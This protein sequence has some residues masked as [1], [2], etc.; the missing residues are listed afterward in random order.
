[1]NILHLDSSILGTGSVTRSLGQRLAQRLADE[2]PHAR[3]SYRDLAADPIPH[4]TGESLAAQAGDDPTDIMAEFLAADIVVIGAPMY[5]FSI[6]SQLKA[7]IDRIAVAGK[8]FAYSADGPVGLAGGKKVYI[9]SGRGS[10]YQGSPLEGWDFQEP[11]LRTVFA[12]IGITDI[13]FIRA[14][15]VARTDLRE[16]AISS[17]EAHIDTLELAIEKVLQAA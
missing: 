14:E 7:W 1:M 9:L 3:L 8:T 16:G 11:Y 12:F 15:G 10:A 6:S 17:A 4:L 5:N 13:T 2:H